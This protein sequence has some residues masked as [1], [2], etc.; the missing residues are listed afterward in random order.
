MPDDSKSLLG[1]ALA[2]WTAGDR[3]LVRDAIA[4]ISP[5]YG[6]DP[7]PPFGKLPKKHRDLLLYGPAASA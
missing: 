3:K 5:N 7:D 4:A 6:I 1:G 2:P